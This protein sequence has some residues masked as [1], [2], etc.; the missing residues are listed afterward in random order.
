MI[1]VCD[2]WASRYFYRWDAF[3]LHKVLE[4]V[5][6][7][8]LLNCAAC[9][10][11]NIMLSCE[12]WSM[13]CTQVECANWRFKEHLKCKCDILLYEIVNDGR[14]WCEKSMTRSIFWE[15]DMRGAKWVI[16]DDWTE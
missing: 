9:D 2:Y 12:L 7:D 11:W 13:W 1:V 14:G 4:Q 16:I 3:N 5:E 15:S 10:V 6:Q 8:N